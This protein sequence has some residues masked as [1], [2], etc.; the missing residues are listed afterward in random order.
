MHTFS[1]TRSA[2]NTIWYTMAP[3]NH[4]KNTSS[5][6]MV[7][8][9]AWL[10]FLTTN[11]FSNWP[12]G[13]KNKRHKHVWTFLEGYFFCR[14]RTLQQTVLSIWNDSVLPLTFRKFSRRT[15]TVVGSTEWQPNIFPGKRP[16]NTFKK[17]K[18]KGMICWFFWSI[19]Q[20][21]FFLIKLNINKTFKN[22]LKFI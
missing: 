3:F 5:E 6:D 14:I 11:Y 7:Q 12:N 22:H 17:V 10:T 16:W 15:I 21:L 1:T 8:N 9:P 4:P 13:N 20:S 18:M 2:S 19:L